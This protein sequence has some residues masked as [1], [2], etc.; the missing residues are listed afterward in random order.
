MGCG[1]DKSKSIFF[2]AMTASRLAKNIAD[3]E[4][5]KIM[6][7]TTYRAESAGKIVMPV[8]QKYTSRTCS[9]CGKIKHDLKL[10]DRIYHCEI[11]DLTT[12]S[13]HVCREG[14]P[15]IHTRGY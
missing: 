13:I 11:Y 4:W 12:E 14:H 8:D 3:A 10:L 6:Q 5:N 2:Y 9:E 15:R 7:Y 1:W